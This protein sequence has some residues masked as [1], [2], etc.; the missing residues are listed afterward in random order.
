MPTLTKAQLAAENAALRNEVNT[1]REQLANVTSVAS[2]INTMQ[3]RSAYEMPQWQKDRAAA[4]AEAK[5]LA[6]AGHITVKV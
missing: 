1:L 4:M 2:A 5:A 6:V 3:R